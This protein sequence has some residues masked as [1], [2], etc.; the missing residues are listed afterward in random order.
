V[1][2]VLVRLI[3]ATGLAGLAL[4]ALPVIALAGSSEH[5]GQVN[6]QHEEGNVNGSQHRTT[7]SEKGDDRR[8]AKEQDGGQSPGSRDFRIESQTGEHQ[9]PPPRLPLTGPGPTPTPA[10][11]PSPVAQPPQRATTSAPPAARTAAPTV[12]GSVPRAAPAF[13]STLV[14]IGG[15]PAASATQPQAGLAGGELAIAPAQPRL[16]DPPLRLRAGINLPPLPIALPNLP[17]NLAVTLAALPLLLV[18]W[19]LLLVRTL[20]AVG[21]RRQALAI[22]PLAAELGIEPARLAALGGTELELLRDK[23]AFDELTGVM[24]RAAGLATL[25]REVARARRLGAVLTVAF[26]DVD[27]LKS[28]NDSQGH[29]AGDALLKAAASSLGQRLRAEDVVFRYGGDEFVCV[30]PGA[31]PADARRILEDARRAGASTGLTF[32]FGLAALKGPAE[33]GPA[34]LARADAELVRNRNARGHRRTSNR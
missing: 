17:A 4:F 3:L 18:I 20:A 2:A 10:P 26:V 6:S 22:Q 32:S 19:L 34:L 16:D 13:P 1:A 24:R 27:G 28:I 14:V 33:R 23:V 5:H 31:S 12:T 30:L 11:T 25:E 8:K 7:G 29:A 15:V 21:R 9:N